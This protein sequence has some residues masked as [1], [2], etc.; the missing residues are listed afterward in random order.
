MGTRGRGKLGNDT[1]FVQ[2]LTAPDAWPFVHPVTSS[3]CRYLEA[4]AKAAGRA[5]IFLAIERLARLLGERAFSFEAKEEGLADRAREADAEGPVALRK[6]AA[7]RALLIAAEELCLLRQVQ[8][9]FD[10]RLV[11]IPDNLAGLDGRVS[12]AQAQRAELRAHAEGEMKLVQYAPLRVLGDLLIC[13]L[14]GKA[15]GAR[16]CCGDFW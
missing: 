5:S 1:W 7:R 6:R 10:L 11:G 4:E 8:C 13:A 16:Q 9:Q 12:A 15:H 2:L 3:R 14:Q